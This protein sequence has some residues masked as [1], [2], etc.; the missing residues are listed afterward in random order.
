[1]NG[2]PPPPPPTLGSYYHNQ[3]S[4]S[5]GPLAPLNIPANHY[6]HQ[7]FPISSPVGTIA[8]PHHPHH[9]M[10]IDTHQYPAQQI[11]YKQGEDLTDQ[12]MNIVLNLPSPNSS[13]YKTQ[14]QI[15]PLM[16]VKSE[17]NRYNIFDNRQDEHFQPRQYSINKNI[18]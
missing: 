4:T 17:K 6:Q 10:E 12:A 15:S 13:S 9:L 8:P 11:S 1:M 7:F 3:A 14:P 16:G 2:P 5:S 18:P